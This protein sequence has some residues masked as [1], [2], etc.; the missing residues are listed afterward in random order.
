MQKDAGPADVARSTELR[1]QPVWNH[2]P[3]IKKALPIMMKS[4]SGNKKTACTSAG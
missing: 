3:K 1:T 4:T 2:Y